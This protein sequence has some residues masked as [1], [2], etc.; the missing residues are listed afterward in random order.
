MVRHWMYSGKSE[1]SEWTR[2]RKWGS[3]Y[4]LN[5][6]KIMKR[7]QEC[8]IKHR[9]LSRDTMKWGWFSTFQNNWTGNGKNN[10]GDGLSWGNYKHEEFTIS[11][12]TISSRDV[13]EIN[14]RPRVLKVKG[15]QINHSWN[16]LFWNI[17]D[18]FHLEFI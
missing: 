15:P 5:L 16:S 11:K 6:C 1:H 12:G 3:T 4:F 13:L 7:D 17:Y 8:L 14:L 2:F 9:T 18:I 10:E